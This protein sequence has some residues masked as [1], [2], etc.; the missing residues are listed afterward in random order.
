M[1]LN[2]PLRGY[3]LAALGIL[4]LSP[5]GLLI[6]LLDADLWTVTF[7][8]SSFIAVSLFLFMVLLNRGRVLSAYLN[9][10][11]YAVLIAIS[12][13]V[14]N[15]FFVASIQNTSVAHTLIIVGAA[16]IVAA[17]LGMIFLREKVNRHSWITIA[18]VFSGLI[19][20]VYDDQHSSLLG[21]LFAFI[22]CL[23]WASVFV[24][25]R[26]SQMTNM[27][28]AMSLSGFINALWSFP[29]AQLD[30]LSGQQWLLALLLGSLVGMAHAMLTTAPR[31][32]PA[33][34]VALFMPLET[35]F[36]SLLVWWLL[37]E[38]PGILSLIA[39]L[40]IILAIMLNSLIQLRLYR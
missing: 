2:S 36:G 37:G 20:V 33:A 22:A 1:N 11:R 28:A 17:I 15:I 3:L 40:V 8:R 14:S 13:A 25:A 27:V 9:L 5:D 32:I 31:W 10:D 16:P 6:R 39:G 12:M 34:E 24:L 4:T 18:V 38:Y 30:P 23:L 26:L 35:V 19:I 7:L 29:L 21:D